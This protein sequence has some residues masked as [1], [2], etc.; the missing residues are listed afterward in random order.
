MDS[1]ITK[2]KNV[3]NEVVRIGCE[4]RAL[5]YFVKIEN[6]KKAKRSKHHPKPSIPKPQTKNPTPLHT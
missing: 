1:K 3:V 4:T 6:T 5:G 2:P